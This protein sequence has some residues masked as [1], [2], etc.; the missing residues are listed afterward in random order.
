MIRLNGDGEDRMAKL[1]IIGNGLDLAHNMPT[2]FDPDF[3]D[4]SERIEGSFFWDLYQSKKDEIW[5]D[6]ENLLGCPD[7]N[8]LEDIFIGY[9]PDYSS[10]S[11]SDRDGI[12]YRAQSCGHLDSALK[13]FAK[14][15]EKSVEKVQK[16][17]DIDLILDKNGYFLSFNYTHTLENIYGIPSE[18]VL[19]IHGEV[20]ADNLALGYPKGNYNPEKYSY[21]VRQKGRGS[22]AQIDVEDYITRAIKDYNVRTA[23]EKLVEKCKSFYKEIRIDLLEKFL[24]ENNCSINEIIVYGHSCAIDYEYF[25]YLNKRYPKAS[26]EFHVKGKNQKNNIKKLIEKYNIVNAHIQEL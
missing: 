6:F 24:D 25:E 26:W 7:Y 22:Y 16:N 4:I 20:G 17:H 13:E 18:N 8:T 19:H 15:A 23:Y 14:K 2:R 10:D 9:E 11:E 3:K 21:D 1:F 12:I 5:S